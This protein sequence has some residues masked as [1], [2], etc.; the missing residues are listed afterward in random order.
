MKIFGIEVSGRSIRLSLV[1]DVIE[2]GTMIGWLAL[3]LAG[4]GLVF[5]LTI[6]EVLGIVVLAV[7]LTVEH[8]LA[9]AAGK[10]A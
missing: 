1:H 4:H 10:V 5:K 8:I 9:L 3:V 6:Y 2:I 7:G